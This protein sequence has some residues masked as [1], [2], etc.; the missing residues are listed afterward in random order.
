[1][2]LSTLGIATGGYLSVIGFILLYF[3]SKEALRSLIYVNFV[4]PSQHYGGVNSVP[5][6]Y[7]ILQNYWNHWVIA[8]SG[9]WWTIPMASVLIVPLLLIA[10]LP[11]LLPVLGARYRWHLARPEILLYWLCG[12]A[13]WMAEFHRK[14]MAH[15]VFGSPLLIIL[16][17]HFLAEYHEKIARLALQIISIS[18]TSLATFN[19]LCALLAAH[20]ITTRVGSMAT[21]QDAP[22]LALLEK[23]VA[24]GDEIFAYPYC[25]RYYFLASTTNPT[26][27]SILTYN[28]NTPSQFQEVVHIL[29]QHKVRYVMWDV[30]FAR[31]TG[32]VFPGSQQPPPGGYIIEPYLESHYKVVQVVDGTRIMERKADEQAN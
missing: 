15:L 28:Y 22:A 26:P 20:P 9:F 19:L 23:L 32:S 29:E 7:G 3:W 11:A 31:L 25:P 6:A 18:A 4:W 2:S 12:I 21:F 1:V 24:P 30:N 16:C 10:A 17:I 14:E 13:L 27:Y 5:Y 8:R